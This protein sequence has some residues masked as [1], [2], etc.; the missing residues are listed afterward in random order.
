MDQK[1]IGVILIIVALLVAGFVLVVQ[2]NNEA[3]ADKYMEEEGT[4]YLEDGT[5]LHKKDLPIYVFG[6]AVAGVLFLFGFYLFFDKTQKMITEHQIKVSSAL[7]NAKKEERKKDEFNAFL[8]GFNDE[9][10]KILSAI[11]N[12]DGIQQSTLRYR[13]NISKTQLSLILKSL[14][15]KNIVKRKPS[16]KTK[17]V[18]LVKRF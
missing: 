7:A 14:E 3:F 8:G 9:E 12:Q 11:R 18:F 15:E 2:R 13:T 10:Q 1:Y 6:W 17:Q 16:G 4:C 5:C